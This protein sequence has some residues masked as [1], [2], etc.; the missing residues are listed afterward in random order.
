MHKAGAL[1]GA[2]A[3]RPIKKIYQALDCSNFVFLKKRS[4]RSVVA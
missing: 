2:Q 1:Q 3:Q 4:E